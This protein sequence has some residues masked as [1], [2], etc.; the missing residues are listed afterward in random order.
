[1]QLSSV[2]Q[3]TIEAGADAGQ[4]ASN[5]PQDL[6][7]RIRQAWA[8]WPAAPWALAAVGIMSL[9]HFWDL[10]RGGLYPWDECSYA[11]RAHFALRGHWLDQM[12]YCYGYQH[13]NGFY[14]GAFPPLLIWLMAASMKLWGVTTFAIRLPSAAFGA[15][16]VWLAYKWARDEWG[17]GCGVWTA[18]VLTSWYF[19]THYSQRAQFD[20]PVVF[21]TMLT[22]YLG[23]KY[24]RTGRL[25]WLLWAGVAMGLG[26]MTKI[27]VAGFAAV[28]LLLAA[29]ALWV[30][31]ELKWTRIVKDQVILNAIGVG[32]MLP[33]HIYMYMRYNTPEMKALYSPPEQVTWTENGFLGYWWGYH[34]QMRT[35]LAE[36]NKSHHSWH[37][38]L[39]TAWEKLHPLWTIL[40]LCVVA[41]AAWRIGRWLWM[42]WKSRAG[43]GPNEDGTIDWS[44]EHTLLVPLVWLLFVFSISAYSAG[45]YK[46]Y[47]IPMLPPAALLTGR[48]LTRMWTHRPAEWICALFSFFVLFKVI[49]SR[50]GDY[51]DN[52]EN[53]LSYDP[54]MVPPGTELTLL[55][56]IKWLVEFIWPV[57]IGA[58]GVVLVL[59]ILRW[60]FTAMSRLTLA[61]GLVGV[62]FFGY[63]EGLSLNF[64]W[65]SLKDD[66]DRVWAWSFVHREIMKDDFDKLIYIGI[67][68]QPDHYFYLDGIFKGWRPEIEY[69]VIRPVSMGELQPL[70]AED[71]VLIVL[72][73]YW[74]KRANWSDEDLKVLFKHYSI[75]EEDLE[76]FAVLR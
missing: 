54:A 5:P 62:L 21:F 15:G 69:E 26:L 14:S 41:W 8:G 9:L 23:A 66:D 65:D 11:L 13:W 12:P 32:L 68:D 76:H 51:K 3:S 29:T 49:G 60:K 2:K 4:S 22:V 34:V 50:S 30:R 17:R 55:E 47:L 25:R 44:E 53:W 33:W 46:T 7:A 37:F 71:N 38:Y 28:A 59:E 43:N 10:G 1:M 27:L 39:D 45:Q 61:V 6:F 35:Q 48:F 70:P 40:I 63:K 24:Y 67:P 18:F 57:A 42:G 56:Q 64:E 72:Q 19:F 75:V 52:L 58:A 74:A 73:K 16:C 20:V 36:A 31:G